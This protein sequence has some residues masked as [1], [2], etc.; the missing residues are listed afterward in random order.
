MR[1]FYIFSILLFYIHSLWTQNI[2]DST[3]EEQKKSSKDHFKIEFTDQDGNEGYLPISIL[4][5][6]TEGPVFT[7]VAGVHGYEY[8]P[9]MAAQRLITEIDIQTLEGTLIVVPIA[10]ISSFYKR[11]PYVNPQDGKNLNRIF[12]GRQDGSISEQIAHF[13]TTNIIPVSD[14]FLDVH[15][16]DACEDLLPY[17][18]YYNNTQKPDQTALASKLS[19]N[20]GFQYIVSYPYTISDTEPAKYAFKQA[21]QDGK[22]G[23]SIECGKLGKVDDKSVSLILKGVV[24]MLSTLEMYP[25]ENSPHQNIIRTDSQFYIRSKVQGIFYSDYKAGDWVREGDVVGFT[26]NEFGEVLEKYKAANEGI[27]LY[28]LATPPINVDDTVMCISS[29]KKN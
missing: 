17:V 2:F 21:V 10:N 19:E 26:T 23:L 7:V 25:G 22:T 28:K 24:S 13:I 1:R 3:F 5:G 15:G 11:T 27:I 29:M 9:I 18:C 12:P 14:I 6:R 20:S 16:G 8:P 4:K